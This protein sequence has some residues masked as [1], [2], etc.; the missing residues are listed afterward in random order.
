MSGASWGGSIVG[1]VAI[2]GSVDAT[3]AA[4]LPSSPVNGNQ[5]IISVAGSF[6]DDASILPAA[7]AF[8]V[9]DAILWDGTNW[10]ARESGDDS[11]KTTLNLS[12]LNNAATSRTNLDVYSKAEVDSIMLTWIA[13]PASPATAVSK[14]GYLINT[15]SATYALTL[16]ATPTVGD[17]VGVS[18]FAGN[19]S[20]NN[21]TIGRN[22]ELIDGDAADLVVDVDKSS[23]MLVYSGATFGWVFLGLTKTI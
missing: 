1:N 10:L 18:D 22:S 9:G 17:V 12:D 14:K 4:N 19:S 2:K 20:V 21:I 7:Y 8:T 15:A 16:P 13:A 11:L 3:L 5:W 23:F 6:E